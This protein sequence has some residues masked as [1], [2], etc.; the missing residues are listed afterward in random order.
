MHSLRKLTV[1]LAGCLLAAAPS[2][3][4]AQA[5]R[6]W[7]SASGDDANPCTRAAP[8]VSLD[9]AMGK[10][11]PYGEVD[12]AGPVG[13]VGGTITK[14]I[15]ID[16]TAGFVLS[17][18]DTTNPHG[19]AIFVQAGASDT[20]VLRG[21]HLLGTSDSGLGVSDSDAGIFITS[22][23]SVVVDHCLISGFK[24][25]GLLGVPATSDF[26]LVIHD[27]EFLN[28]GS[29]SAPAG[30]IGAVLLQTIGGH[31]G[32]SITDS[33]LAWSNAGGGAGAVGVSTE[34]GGMALINGAIAHTLIA[35]PQS[36]TA[37]DTRAVVIDGDGGAGQNTSLMLDDVTVTGGTFALLTGL[38]S[39]DGLIVSRTSVTGAGTGIR[40][41][42]GPIYS[43][44]D[45]TVN[46]NGGDGSFT[47]V[48][49]TK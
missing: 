25:F 35:L 4:A 8:C 34:A 38:P 9:T 44:G 47:A 21:L 36:V 10:T 43:Y 16:C 26:R 31:I 18:G 3:A 48:I 42:G 40:S 14:S 33:T 27:S 28:D 13:E 24:Q 45:N 17:Y 15:V 22:A 49:P 39:T 5:S 6:T 7:I 32:V 23:A 2:L 30:S 46:G 37:I 1:V 29:P 11:A 20:V 19:D 12:C 41:D